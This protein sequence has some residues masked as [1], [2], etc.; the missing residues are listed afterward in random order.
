MSPK[1]TIGQKIKGLFQKASAVASVMI[2]AGARAI[3]SEKRYDNYA[4]EAYLKNVIAFRSIQLIAQAVASVKWNVFKQ[5]ASG[6]L[7]EIDSH[8]I[9][10][11]LKRP[12]PEESFTFFMEKMAAYHVLTA[13]SFIEKV[14]LSTGKNAGTPR[15]LYTIRP[16]YIS[17]ILVN[18]T[19][20][21]AG[22]EV[23]GPGGVRTLD[24]DTITRRGPMLHIKGFHPTDNF[25]GAGPSEPASRDIDTDNEA[26][27]WNMRLLQNN[28]RPGMMIMFKGSMGDEQ[29]KHL[30][31]MMNEKYSGAMNAG[32]N[33][34]LENVG[35]G[36]D[37][38][39]Y[40]FSPAEIDYIE[41][42]REK[43]RRICLAYGVPPQLLG[44][45]GDNTYSNYEQAR[46]AFWEDTVIPYI[47]R[48][49][50]EFNWF[51]FDE[52]DQSVL[53]P[54]LDEIPALSPRRKELWERANTSEFLTINE[55]R[56]TVGYDEVEGGDVI[57]VAAS[58][59]PLEMAG[60]NMVNDANDPDK[61]PLKDPKKK[62][63]KDDGKT[64]DE[65]L[66]DEAYGE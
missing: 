34:V 30:T 5:S 21:V 26:T 49:T 22:Y 57:L 45:P 18:G 4:K 56:E 39:P 35:D 29:F 47:N 25:W 48:Y 20:A 62:P 63:P 43:A 23:R 44:I 64:K 38:K 53:V 16:D 40:G 33:I 54:D 11:L 27:E 58:D 52:N 14:A 1:R 8:P 2:P 59:I 51:L 46:L 50:E 37:V 17:K 28:A 31:E 65:D 19:G 36:A 24:I 66:D 41:G 32:K 60:E 10:A 9:M 13:N 12:N 42:G 15:E 55:K 61:K 3:W 7:E 6:K